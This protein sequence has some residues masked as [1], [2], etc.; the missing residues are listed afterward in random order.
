MS[1]D[2][3]EIGEQRDQEVPIPYAEEMA[4]QYSLAR[5]EHPDLDWEEIVDLVVARMDRDAILG[6]AAEELGVVA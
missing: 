3:D 6:H 5:R 2:P 1:P 4:V